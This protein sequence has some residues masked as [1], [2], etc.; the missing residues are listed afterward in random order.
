MTK[1]VVNRGRALGVQVQSLLSPEVEPAERTAG[2]RDWESPR[3]HS[4]IGFARDDACGIDPFMT[5]APFHLLP[6]F[7]LRIIQ[8]NP[9][10][11]RIR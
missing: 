6:R 3:Q 1:R 10:A 11:R 7:D 9:I 2:M 5:S 8:L 4:K